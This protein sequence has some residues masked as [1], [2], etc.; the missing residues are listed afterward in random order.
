[1]LQVVMARPCS[2]VAC[3]LLLAAAPGARAQNSN[4]FRE[5]VPPVPAPA[6]RPAPR[7]RSYA[8]PEPEVVAPAPAQTQPQ[9]QPAITPA[10]VLLSAN[11]IWARVRQVAAFAMPLSGAPPFDQ[12][13]TPPQY[14]ALLGAGGPD[15]WQGN[16]AGDKAILVIEG[17]DGDGTCGVYLAKV[18]A[19]IPPPFGRRSAQPLPPATGSWR[20]WFST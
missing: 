15:T 3:C 4:I 16:H 6:P 11:Q 10:P 20:Q 5:D 8:P 2:A 12:T 7:P 19:T 18:R 14:R 9:P 13:G 17:I 1:M